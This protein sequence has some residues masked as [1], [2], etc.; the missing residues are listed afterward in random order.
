MTGRILRNNRQGVP[1]R[2]CTHKTSWVCLIVGLEF[3]VITFLIFAASFLCVLFVTGAARST[4]SRFAG[5]VETFFSAMVFVKVWGYFLWPSPADIISDWRDA[6][7]PLLGL[8]LSLSEALN[9]LFGL[10][11]DRIPKEYLRSLGLEPN[12][13]RSM[14]DSVDLFEYT[15]MIVAA[16]LSTWSVIVAVPCIL[17]SLALDPNPPM[18][19]SA[20]SMTIGFLFAT[21]VAALLSLGSLIVFFAYLL[22]LTAWDPDPPIRWN[23]ASVIFIYFSAVVSAVSVDLLRSTR[24]LTGF[25]RLKTFFRTLNEPF[26]ERP[27]CRLVKVSLLAG[28]VFYAFLF[29]NLVPGPFGWRLGLVLTRSGRLLRILVR[30]HGQD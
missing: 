2:R 15:D 7:P 9:G 29:L 3:Q 14:P 10:K 22:M 12:L 20:A 27:R 4:P 21:A 6:F 19:G 5:F 23:A 24:T 28:G 18:W 1:T 25:P 30:L 8:S 17:M 11:W 26:Y 16:P 13:A